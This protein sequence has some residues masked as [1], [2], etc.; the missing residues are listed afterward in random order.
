M[1]V[2]SYVVVMAL[3]ASAFGTYGASFFAADSRPFWYPLLT[4]G[5][6][7]RSRRRRVSFQR[8]LLCA[9]APLQ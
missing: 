1:L 5:I 2:L 8:R 7:A 9:F 6:P 3:Y 4:S